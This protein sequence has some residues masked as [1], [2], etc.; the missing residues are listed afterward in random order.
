MNILSVE[1]LDDQAVAR[2]RREA[3]RERRDRRNYMLSCD[4]RT[5]LEKDIS[6]FFSRIKMFQDSEA[7]EPQF[8]PVA[9]EFIKCNDQNEDIALL[10]FARERAKP[11]LVEFP[12]GL[13][14]AAE[15][16][17]RQVAKGLKFKVRV[18]RLIDG[19]TIFEVHPKQTPEEFDADLMKDLGIR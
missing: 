16:R 8:P 6:T 17:L 2:L 11:V 19:W 5:L 18:F 1:V 9:N 14:K 7:V 15:G 3:R 10:R 4:P 13:S 12:G